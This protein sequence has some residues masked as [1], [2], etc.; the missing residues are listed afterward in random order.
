M[1]AT[2]TG[3][4]GADLRQGQDVA[5]SYLHSGAAGDVIYALPAIREHA[6][7]HS[8]NGRA[9]LIL[10]N[11]ANT[12]PSP[13]LTEETGESLAAFIRLQSY[14][15]SCLFVGKDKN[16][17]A[18]YDLDQFRENYFLSRSPG[19][20]ISD[21][22]CDI[23]EVDRACST[24]PWL[25]VRRGACF[26]VVINR[27]MRFQNPQFPWRRVLEKYKEMCVFVGTT[28]EWQQFRFHYGYLP[29]MIHINITELAQIIYSARLF[30]G[31][32]SLCYAIREGFK[33]PSVQETS[34]QWPNCMWRRDNAWHFYGDNFHLP[35]LEDL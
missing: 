18:D 9:R 34:A 12:H 6:K 24:M 13:P 33:L 32:Q 28:N 30:I 29:M 22:V 1:D 27:T 35:D 4:P 17:E 7:Q 2:K 16:P 14:I 19:K 15:D 21:C 20:R 5:T 8:P 3:R 23:L 26:S 31:N 10:S 11:T 25:T